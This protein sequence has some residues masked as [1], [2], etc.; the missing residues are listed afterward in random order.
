MDRDPK[1]RESGCF[2]PQ[3]FATTG[4]DSEKGGDTPLE[5]EP[6]A[7]SDGEGATR[8]CYEASRSDTVA[9]PLVSFPEYNMTNM[10]GTPRTSP[11]QSVCASIRRP[12]GVQRQYLFGRD[13][14]RG[15]GRSRAQTYS[16]SSHKS[17][18]KRT[19]DTSEERNANRY[20]L[21][22]G[23]RPR[24]P[25]TWS[26]CPSL[27]AKPRVTPARY[28]RNLFLHCVCRSC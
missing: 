18:L 19:V 7:A 16:P 21:L 4:T 5:L 2:S 22:G 1:K 17:G 3:L 14:C 9:A 20:H 24:S 27:L 26:F 28:A 12:R 8:R 11:R 10:L 15:F 6:C 25:P 13:E 23:R